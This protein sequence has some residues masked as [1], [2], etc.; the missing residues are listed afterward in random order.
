MEEIDGRSPRGERGLKYR[1]VPSKSEK[2]SR[3]PRGER[4]LKWVMVEVFPAASLSF[5]SRGA[6]IEIQK[7]DSVW[8][9][10]SVVPLAGSVD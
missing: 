2:T 1:S 9:K 4:G 7:P 8:L 5:P 6:W 3:S 10:Q